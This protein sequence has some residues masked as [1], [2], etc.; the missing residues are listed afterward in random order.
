MWRKIKD[1]KIIKYSGC[2]LVD[3]I[4]HLVYLCIILNQ[5]CESSYLFFMFTRKF[6]ATGLQRKQAVQILSGK[7]DFVMIRTRDGS[8]IQSEYFVTQV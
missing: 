8:C 7:A 5:A 3:V 1:T 2:I 6:F 4:L